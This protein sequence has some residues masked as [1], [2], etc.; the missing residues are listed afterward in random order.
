MATHIVWVAR[1]GIS[2]WPVALTRKRN[3][4]CIDAAL[5]LSHSWS[6]EAQTNTMI[7]RASDQCTVD[8]KHGMALVD[9]EVRW[10][11]FAE[12]DSIDGLGS[13]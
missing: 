10:I 13:W 4:A 8:S 2:T 7:L 6:R 1:H 3:Y 5:D 9:M 11:G 12:L